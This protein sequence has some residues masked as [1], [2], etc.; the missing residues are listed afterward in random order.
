MTTDHT[1]PPP[2]VEK[3]TGLRSYRGGRKPG[4]RNK[5]PPC[6]DETLWMRV[7][8]IARRF[9]ISQTKVKTWIRKGDVNSVK[10]GN[11][12][13]VEVASVERLL[14]IRS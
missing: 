13:L 7:P 2:S 9:S 1:T 4:T 5:L 6:T 3:P 14:G 10:H 11:V 8:A 12:R